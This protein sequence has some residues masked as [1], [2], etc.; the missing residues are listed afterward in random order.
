MFDLR[1]SSV[2][3]WLDYLFNIWLNLL[4]CHFEPKY[5]I[6]CTKFKINP[7]PIFAKDL[8]SLDKCWNFVNS[9]HTA[10]GSQ[11]KREVAIYVQRKVWSTSAVRSV[12]IVEKMLQFCQAFN[13]YSFFNLF[14]FVLPGL[15]RSP[16]DLRLRVFNV[17]FSTG[18]CD[19]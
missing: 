9:G 6:I 14:Y 8:E 5:V 17:Y 1:V 16:L 2:T 12:E 19:Q 13:L 7:Q 18:Q 3:R 15:N 11:L 10:C 4:N